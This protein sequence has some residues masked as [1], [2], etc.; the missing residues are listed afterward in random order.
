MRGAVGD[1][2]PEVD[3]AASASGIGERRSRVGDLGCSFATLGS[4]LLLESSLGSFHI[5]HGGKEVRFSG[6]HLFAQIV[7]LLG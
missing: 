7:A 4:L 6:A 3:D 1:G 5:R 2:R